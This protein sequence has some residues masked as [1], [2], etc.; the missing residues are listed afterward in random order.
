MITESGRN[1]QRDLWRG[2]L[3]T[4]VF[5][6]GTR[7]ENEV[8]TA[9]QA[10]VVAKPVSLEDRSVGE[11]IARGRLTTADANGALLAEVGVTASSG[12]LLARKTHLPLEKNETVEVEYEILFRVR[13]A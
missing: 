10:Q 13:N 6:T 12:E 11:V 9:L 8:D 3:A 4:V 7:A 5:G 2:I 1:K